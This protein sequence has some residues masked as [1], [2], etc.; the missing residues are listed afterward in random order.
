MKA[1]HFKKLRKKAKY[2]RVMHSEGLFGTFWTFELD[3]KGELVLA[4]NG[5][6][7]VVRAKKR[8]Y[9][10]TYEVSSYRKNSQWATWVVKLENK[11]DHWK[12]LMYY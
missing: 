5:Y 8:G 12:N 10:L 1:K 11:S 4:R 7:A 6:E 3:T 9:G 2:Y